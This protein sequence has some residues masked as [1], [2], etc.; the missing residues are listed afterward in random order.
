MKKKIATIDIG[1]T[2]IKFSTWS[3]E[4]LCNVTSVDTPK[5]LEEFYEIIQT[6][7]N[8]MK[9]LFHLSGVAISSPGS[10]NKE[11]GCIEGASA[12]PYIHHFP[13]KQQLEDLLELPVSLEND[14]NCAALAE[15]NKTYHNKLKSAVFLVIG[16]GIG[17]SIIIDNTI[18]KGNHLLGG[19][20]GYMLV[21]NHYTLSD[22]CSPVNM[23]KRYNEKSDTHISGK[24]VFSLSNKGDSL[25]KTET[26]NFYSTLAKVIY[27]IQ[28]SLDPEKIIIGGAISSNDSVIK[29]LKK[30][31]KKC[32]DTVQIANIVPDITTCQYKGNANLVGAAVDFQNE[33]GESYN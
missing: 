22:I 10:V 8:K 13:I 6:E 31:V 27:N 23:A 30:W 7:V 28:Y 21:D 33:Y 12:L 25:A 26:D 9:A 20:F 11:T 29:E 2:S 19:E 4:E 3:S 5:S 15:L 17:G 32:V 14:A 24:D 16:T 18:I 1:G